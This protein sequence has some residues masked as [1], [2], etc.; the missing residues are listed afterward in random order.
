[1]NAKRQYKAAWS[2]IRL[3]MQQ[4]SFDLVGWGK[5]RLEHGSMATAAWQSYHFNRAF[6]GWLDT[7]RQ[8]QFSTKRHLRGYQANEDYYD[9]LPFQGGMKMRYMR[10]W[11]TGPLNSE[12]LTGIR[13]QCGESGDDPDLYEI[14]RDGDEWKCLRWV[15]L[16]TDPDAHAF[17]EIA[18]AADCFT[19][20][21][22]A[23]NDAKS[24]NE[25]E[26]WN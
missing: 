2:G 3:Y 16:E 8:G 1:M 20:M 6:S 23:E 25:G 13:G 9:R 10:F 14:V 18:K 24:R 19:C 26:E 15:H 22:A 11:M 21:V 4:Q 12:E 7:Y 5:F 17:K